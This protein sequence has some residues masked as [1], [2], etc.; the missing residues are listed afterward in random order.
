METDGENKD[1]L[2]RVKKKEK[3]EGGKEEEKVRSLKCS[4]G[5]G[6]LLIMTTSLN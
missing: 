3:R 5:V 6:H 2:K 1:V 4:E